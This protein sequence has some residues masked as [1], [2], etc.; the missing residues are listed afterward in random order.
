MKTT[1][2]SLFVVF[3]F[4]ISFHS[5]SADFTETSLNN[6]ASGYVN[7]LESFIQKATKECEP[8]LQKD[9]VWRDNLVQQWQTKN[10][11]YLLAVQHWTNFYLNR[12]SN[13]S[14]EGLAQYE[15]QKIKS[16]IDMRGTNITREIITG[17]RKEKTL[18]CEEFES[19]LNNDELNVSD[20]SPHHAQLLKM[21]NIYQ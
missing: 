1:F 16:V 12:I 7:M 15:Q 6:E 3:I 8:L 9:N 13:Y 4:S 2:K 18:A 17:N 19:K 21:I 20:Q 11:E 10:E 5:F 14:G